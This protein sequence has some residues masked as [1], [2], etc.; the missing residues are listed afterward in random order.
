[1][2]IAILT[3]DLKRC[4]VCAMSAMRSDSV[5]TRPSV[6]QRTEQRCVAGWCQANRFAL[7]SLETFIVYS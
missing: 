7:G 2:K 3:G 5:A 4:L 6:I 1:M